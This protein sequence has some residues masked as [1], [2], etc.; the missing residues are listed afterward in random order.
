MKRVLLSARWR[1]ALTALFVSSSLWLFAYSAFWL[2]PSHHPHLLIR[3]AWSDTAT[4]LFGGIVPSVFL[5]AFELPDSGSFGL[6]FWDWGCAVLSLLIASMLIW[7]E[8]IGVV[9]T[10]VASGVNAVILLYQLVSIWYDGG[11]VYSM[12]RAVVQRG[13]LLAALIGYTILA[14]SLLRLAVRQRVIGLK[15]FG[16]L[17]IIRFLD[18]KEGQIDPPARESKG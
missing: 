7:R 14:R 3:L 15:R 13:V 5:G 10:A 11:H 17:I 16:P 8:R 18:T 4:T 6:V 9:L 12:T 2:N 1:I